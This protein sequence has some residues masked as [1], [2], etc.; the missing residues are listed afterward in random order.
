MSGVGMAIGL[1]VGGIVTRLYD[2]RG[3]RRIHDPEAAFTEP[4][5]SS[6]DA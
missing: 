3:L 5:N 6:K 1:L 2:R 4:A